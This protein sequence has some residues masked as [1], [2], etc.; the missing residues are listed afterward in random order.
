[1]DLTKYDID[2]VKRNTGSLKFNI[3]AS[4][5]YTNL[6]N[7]DIGFR[8]R[9][10][11]L[12]HGFNKKCQN[13]NKVHSFNLMSHG[14]N[15]QCVMDLTKYTLDSSKCYTDSTKCVMD[16]TKSDKDANK[17]DLVSI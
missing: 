2:L 3:G 15:Q 14:F 5:C 8:P 11:I 9:F 16:L 17:F 10:N 4:K 1:M 7:S 13:S 12:L 6:T